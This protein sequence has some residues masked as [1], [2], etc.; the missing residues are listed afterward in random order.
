MT[1]LLTLKNIDEAKLYNYIGIE[2]FTI[3]VADWNTSLNFYEIVWDGNK[4]HFSQLGLTNHIWSS[5]TLYTEEKKAERYQWFKDFET[6]NKLSSESILNFHKT[7]GKG[8]T[9]YGV[10]MHRG[11]VKMTSITQI[12]KTGDTIEIK[13]INLKTQETSVKILNSFVLIN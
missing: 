12:E 9:D 1:D 13:F 7:A 8:N 11:F 3:V 6:K 4:A 5:S 2:P 10:I